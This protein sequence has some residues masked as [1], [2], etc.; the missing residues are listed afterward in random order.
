MMMRGWAL[1]CFCLHMATNIK[2][3]GIFQN[4]DANE[5]ILVGS[6]H[7]NFQYLSSLN[8]DENDNEKEEWAKKTLCCNDEDKED[9]DIGQTNCGIYYQ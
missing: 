7:L 2:K 8:N 1:G 5:N 3:A 6:L 4:S 9:K